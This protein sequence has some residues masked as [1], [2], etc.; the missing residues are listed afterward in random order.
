MK[1]LTLGLLVAALGFG[2]A[3][4]VESSAR[5][6]AQTIA[7]LSYAQTNRE[8]TD[9]A[10]NQTVIAGTIAPLSSAATQPVHCANACPQVLEA[11]RASAPLDDEDHAVLLAGLA[12]VARYI[13]ADANIR[14]TL[15]ELASSSDDG[16][17][18]ALIRVAFEQAGRVHNRELG[19]SLLGATD[20][21][22]RREGVNVLAAEVAFDPTLIEPLTQL[23]ASEM[24]VYTK[25]AT[26]RGLDKP[27]HFRGERAILAALQ[28]TLRTEINPQLLG[29][30]LVVSARL[31]NEPEDI[32]HA[33][34]KAIVSA[35]EDYRL[36]GLQALETILRSPPEHQPPLGWQS[37]A[38]ARATLEA[39][40][41]QDA[42]R[43]PPSVV[44]EASYIYARHFH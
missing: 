16:N 23:L 7:P 2:I 22:K 15:I 4:L 9:P 40:L 43:V 38:Q 21:R 11:L 30:A 39:L 19:T 20:A 32:F 12:D 17:K 36:Y 33:V 42:L 25:I 28:S 13:K 24:D 44:R 27:A 34:S 37:R 3:M 5:P 18:R 8:P 1:I 41:D 35:D 29:E 26:I 31:V 6:D 10:L 14:A